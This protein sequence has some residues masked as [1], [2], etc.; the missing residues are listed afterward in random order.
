MTR[1]L[2]N[3]DGGKTD[4]KGH[5][6]FLQS[7]TLGEVFSGG[8]VRQAA[9]PNMTVDVP[10]MDALIRDSANNYA[11]HTWS[12]AVENVQVPTANASNPRKDYIIAYVDRTV[13]PDSTNANNAGIWKLIDVAGTPAGSPVYPTTSEIQAS[14]VGT[15]PYIIIAGISVG[16]AVTSI[17]NA[18]I[19]DLRSFVRA[20]VDFIDTAALRALSVTR[21]KLATTTRKMNP[22]QLLRLAGTGG[23]MWPEAGATGAIW[24]FQVPD[25]YV[26]GDITVKVAYRAATAG[27]VVH[28]VRSIYRFRDNVAIVQLVNAVGVD[29]SVADLASHVISFPIAASGFVAGDVLRI[30]LTR[31]QAD[32][33]ANNVECDGFWIEYT[34]KS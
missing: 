12:D 32:S 10:V 28:L 2:S 26:S 22:P 25:D 19:T 9:T 5:L 30:D 15:N 17:T 14:A 1:F 31:N 7:L 24:L 11:F 16:A 29:Y 27:G 4:E 3:R 8:L 13:T 34:G 23:A 18:A 6:R 21:D 33:S 20:N